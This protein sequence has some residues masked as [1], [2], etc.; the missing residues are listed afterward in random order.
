M[1]RKPTPT[2]TMKLIEVLWVDR[3]VTFNKLKQM[4]TKPSV[5]ASTLGV[6]VKC[7]LPLS[8]NSAYQCV[9]DHVN[10]TSGLLV[11]WTVYFIH[12]EL[13]PIEQSCV[14]GLP[15][16]LSKPQKQRKLIVYFT[17]KFVLIR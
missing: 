10:N 1:A 15:N 17:P 7:V 16:K 14:R 2:C 13:S 9:Y 6:A 8:N 12:V 3:K 11:K 5:S 4:S